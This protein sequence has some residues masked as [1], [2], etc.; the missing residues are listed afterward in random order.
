MHVIAGFNHRPTW[1]CV[2]GSMLDIYRF[3]GCSIS[4]DMLLGLGEG[5][6]AGYFRFKGQAPFF[7]GRANPKPS[8]EALTCA[9]TGVGMRARRSGSDEA[10]EKALFRSLASGEPVMVQVDMGFL[11]YFD[12][13]GEEYHFGGHV[14]VACGLDEEDQTVSIADRDAEIHPVSFDAVRKARA[15]RFRPF[16]PGRAWWEFDATGFRQ[17]TAA[18]IRTAIENQARAML[19][20]PIRNLGV[21]GIRKAAAE[22]PKWPGLADGWSLKDALFNLYIF[23]NEVGGSGGGFFRFMLSRFLG[24]AAALGCGAALKGVSERFH[25]IAESWDHVGD[26]CKR[27]S[28]S[29]TPEESLGPISEAIAALAD[30]EEAAWRSALEAAGTEP[31]SSKPG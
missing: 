23:T 13:G 3:H 1:H 4:E 8:S 18:E 9:R 21:A 15:S 22:L 2:T 11:P 29:S 5:V 7:G 31:H 14:V 19:E 25:A 16:P 26:M 6:G 28:Q 20:P 27:A 17:P 10:A 30:R 24:E 12:F